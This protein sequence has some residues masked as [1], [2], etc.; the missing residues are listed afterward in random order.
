[1]LLLPSHT[2]KPRFSFS[3]GLSSTGV[4]HRQVLKICGVCGTIAAQSGES[5]LLRITTAR[6]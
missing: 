4:G 5:V 1:M 2:W 3:I 6:Y